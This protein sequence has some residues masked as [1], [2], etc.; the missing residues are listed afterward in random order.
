M[1]LDNYT[2][3]QASVLGWL[4][5]P[6]DPLVAPAVPDMVRLFEA[7]ANR[8]LRVDGA[9]TGVFLTA[10]PGSPVLTMP[11]DFQ[12]LHDAYASL[13]GDLSKLDYLPTT[14]P[15]WASLLTT[16]GRPRYHNPHSGA[17]QLGPVPDNPYLISVNYTRGV[18]PLGVAGR[19]TNWLLTR[20]P[21]AYLFGTLVEA[22]AYIGHD[23]RIALWL[24]RR[25]ASFASIEMAD[26][27]LRWSGGPLQIRVDGITGT[28]GAGG[29]GGGGRGVVPPSSGGSGVGVV[30]SDTPPSPPQG[31]W[32]D[33]VSAQLF[34]WFDDGSSTQWVP[35][36]NQAG[37]GE[38]PVAMLSPPSGGTVVLGSIA[39]HYVNNSSTLASLTILLPPGPN[40][41]DMMEIGFRNPVTSL[42]IQN[43]SGVLVASAP[44][45]A[46]GP[47]AALQFRFIDTATGWV[48]WK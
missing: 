28:G 40:T 29:G 45:S 11:A 13:N 48:Y 8:R 44:T 5:R 41:N 36:I 2:S 22:E 46:Y 39:P 38:P 9:Q 16:S 19:T 25:E 10:T 23:E 24:Q 20:D 34:V 7:E 14:D 27:K 42:T 15:L 6:G 4:A 12:A 47:G 21:D 18:P 1:A 35:T 31:L 26:R 30:I 33:S 3:L 37:S 32:F 43:S 17:L